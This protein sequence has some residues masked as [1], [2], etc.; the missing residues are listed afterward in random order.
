MA[1]RRRWVRSSAMPRRCIRKTPGTIVLAQLVGVYPADFRS[2][3][4]KSALA[5]MSATC[6]LVGTKR[7]PARNQGI[8]LSAPWLAL[9]QSTLSPQAALQTLMEALS[10][11]A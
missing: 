9:A 5:T 7:G 4:I 3:V 2:G 1:A 6:Q 11:T 10:G 8:E